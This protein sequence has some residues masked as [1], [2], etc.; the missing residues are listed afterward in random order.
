M[1]S[2]DAMSTTHN[3]EV[4][5]S[6][7]APATTQNRR[8]E[9]LSQ[10]HREGASSVNGSRMAAQAAPVRTSRGPGHPLRTVSWPSRRRSHDRRPGCQRPVN[11]QAY[12]GDHR[13]QPRTSYAEMR[14]SWLPL[15]A[16]YGTPPRP[17]SS[18][19]SAHKSSASSGDSPNRRTGGG[20]LA[21]RR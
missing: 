15:H 18:G 13:G 21:P 12:L 20:A 17:H 10:D 14:M 11:S 7:P 1:P 4:A 3:P 5:G 9:A 19:S 2:V 8:S 16:F 6:N